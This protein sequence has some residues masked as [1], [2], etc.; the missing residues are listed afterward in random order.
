MD[1]TQHLQLPFIA[2]SQ[3]QKHVTHNEALVRLDALVQLA[4]LDRDL[5]VPP[6][7]PAD[8]ARYIIAAGATGL[9][10]GK[11]GQIAHWTDGLWDYLVPRTGWA[12]W[13]E[14]ESTLAFY[15]G[16]DWQLVTS[17]VLPTTTSQ[18]G[19]NTSSSGINRLSVSSAATLLNHEGAGHQLKLN[20]A[21]ATDT[22]SLLY[23]T[24]FSG[25]AEMGLAGDDDFHIKVSADGASWNEA[26]V[27]NRAT[28]GVSFPNTTLGAVLSVAGRTGAV[29]LAADDV[30][31]LGT[32]A[33]KN[34]G[35]AAGQV[36]ALD[37]SARLPA[38]DGS[39]ITNLSASA[40]PAGAVVNRSYAEYTANADINAVIP[41]DDTIPQ[42][43]E[44]TLVLSATIT[45]RSATNL[46]RV[47]AILS[48]YCNVA[49]GFA[50][51]AL[52]LN[53]ETSARRSTWGLYNQTG[54]VLVL[55]AQFAAG[56]T[57]MQTLNVRVGP[58]S[59][60]LR[61]NGSTSSRLLGGS[62]ACTLLIEEIKA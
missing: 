27:V 35:A 33:T 8:G 5:T 12:C 30:S 22:A 60:T 39:Q 41:G 53:A 56:S 36:V 6:S 28:G 31:G 15:N 48:G 46:L 49:S 57:A 9:W 43:N 45:P 55:D 23:Q 13:L 26:L 54:G 58:A 2:A 17:A 7:A 32:A 20:K 50:V 4:V 11:A 38:V 14:D 59:G 10:A 47:Q 52:F 51:A 1:R 29:T 16:S 62:S 37:G 18:L 40:F 3:A 25:R 24:G 42:S 34:T 21:S 44:G 19:V 61:L